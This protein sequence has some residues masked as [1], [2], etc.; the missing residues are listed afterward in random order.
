MQIYWV[1]HH[2]GGLPCLQPPAASFG[3]PFLR[4]CSA[5]SSF[6]RHSRT[7]RNALFYS[8]KNI[9]QVR[10]SSSRFSGL[11]AGFRKDK[12]KNLDRVPWSPGP[13]II[14]NF[15]DNVFLLFLSGTQL[16]SVGRIKIVSPLYARSDTRAASITF[17]KKRIKNPFMAR[18]CS[19]YFYGLTPILG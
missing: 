11:N 8:C 10:F 15:L 4:K 1:N 18:S 5:M 7:L 14:Q 9:K 6:G 3:H 19:K 12:G 2:H 17:L 13:C 16:V